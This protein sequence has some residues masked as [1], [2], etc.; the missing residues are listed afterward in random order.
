MSKGEFMNK[1]S[2]ADTIRGFFLAFQKKD[3]RRAEELMAEDFTFSSPRDDRIG[4]AE[5]F[6]RCWP[7]SDRIRNFEIEQ[8]FES[9][10]EAFV[11][12]VAERTSDGG[13]FR[14]TE[15]FRVEGGKVKEVDV[16]FG[17]DLPL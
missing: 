1:P 6:V 10:N 9:G 15:Y 5:Y 16:Y 17:R 8:L 12:Y 7:N 11:R 3:R 4:K 14:N 13:R 2:V